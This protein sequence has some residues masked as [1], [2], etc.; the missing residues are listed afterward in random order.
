MRVVGLLLGTKGGASET[1][2]SPGVPTDF[3]PAAP[4]CRAAGNQ[5][6]TPSGN[7]AQPGR[8]ARCAPP[9]P[10]SDA[11]RLPARRPALS[12]GAWTG[13]HLP[14]SVSPTAEETPKTSQPGRQSEDSRGRSEATRG[15]E[16]PTPT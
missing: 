16:A 15:W 13:Q 7:A 2:F 9:G 12:S 8:L 11:S 1:D 4:T 3:G 5:R 10:R 14:G 6:V